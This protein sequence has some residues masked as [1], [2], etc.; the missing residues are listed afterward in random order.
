MLCLYSISFLEAQSCEPLSDNI[1]LG[2]AAHDAGFQAIDPIHATAG[3][4][5]GNFVVAWESRDGIDGNETGAYF[6][7]FQLDGTAVTDVIAPYTDVN[8]DGTGHQGIFGPKVIALESGFVMVWESEDGSGDSGP[9]GNIGEEKRDV[10]FR[11]YDDNGMAVSGSTRLDNEGREDNLEFVLPLSTGGFA[12]LNSIGEDTPGNNKDDFF[13]HTFNAQGVENEGSPVNISGGAHDAAFQGVNAVQA[14][15]EL[16]GGKFAV[17][18]EARDGIDGEGNGGFFRIF[19]A[20]GSAVTE[21]IAPYA[22]VNPMGTGDQALFGGRVIGLANGNMVMAWGSGS[23]ILS[24]EVFFRVYDS[25]GLA[26]SATTRIDDDQI[27]EATLS[28]LVPLTGGG[29]AILFHDD[30]RTAGG[31]TDDYYVRVYDSNG[32]ALSSSTE[33]SGG[34]HTNTFSVSQTN[35]PGIIALNN[36]NFAVGWATRTGEDGTGAGAFYRVFNS[37]GAPVTGVLTP[38]SDINPDGTGEQSEFGPV[39]KAL[40]GSF[41][42]AWQSA[43]GPGDVARDVYH[44]VINND[45]TPYCGS[46][47]TNSGNDAIEETIEDI[48]PLSNGN[49]ALVYKDE[50]ADNKDDLFVRVT[51]AV[52]AIKCPTIGS[53]VV[54]PNPFCEGSTGTIT[55]SGLENMAQTDNGDQDYGIAYAFFTIIGDDPY[56]KFGDIGSISFEQLSNGGTTAVFE[57]VPLTDF[58]PI[59]A[60]YLTPTPADAACRPFLTVN[61]EEITSPSVSFTAPADIFEDAGVQT[62]LDGGTPVGGVYSGPGVTD[63]GNG[64][65]YSFDPAAAGGVGTYTI[66]YIYTSEEGCEASASDDIEVLE[67]ILQ[68]VPID[69]INDVNPN[70]GVAVSDGE[71]VAIQGIV[72]CIDFDSEEGYA[73]WILESNGDGMFVYSDTLVNDYQATEGD[74][75]KIEGFLF[76]FEGLLEINPSTITV[77]SQGKSLV[78][79]VST[80]ELNESLENQLVALEITDFVQEDIELIDFEDGDYFIIFPTSQDTFTVAISGET[81]IDVEFL[82]EYLSLGGITS[83]TVT[84]FVGQSDEDEPYDAGYFLIACSEGD[85]D[86]VSNV[87]EPAW[88]SELLVYP[89][90]ATYEVNINAPVKIE[91]LRLLNMQGRVLQNKAIDNNIHTLDLSALPKG[92]YQIQ[93]ISE[94][95]MVNRQV[96]R[97]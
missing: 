14:M 55:V 7:V 94:E 37:T 16:S 96:V 56:N 64:M 32:M 41:V 29:F 1:N 54:D 85:F 30:E 59:L 53:V 15:A 81:G 40:A 69:D 33:I 49:F 77:I 12:I 87:Q 39:M 8:P 83:Y 66:T 61:L 67:K 28:G 38:Y 84:G 91:T 43:G 3:L 9:S 24:E 46:T 88:A 89:N 72:H 44:R 42:I 17:T 2:G 78:S 63:D 74:E 20:D 52:P 4:S 23:L 65:T 21:V 92:V 50:D 79:P 57:N 5:N 90:P 71:E 82:T 34:L 26:V 27:G 45:G 22:D 18:W 93:L 75:I 73:F 13:V 10:F 47:K 97:Q 31:N 60:V 36:G 86:F 58:N 76:Q 62:G 25:N 68:V 70:T 48:V 80:T 11:V 51:G 95:G 6:Q 35:R 19:N